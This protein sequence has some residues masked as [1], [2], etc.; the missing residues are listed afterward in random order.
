[1]PTY[2]VFCFR[3]PRVYPSLIQRKTPLPS[4]LP[5][6]FSARPVFGS[7]S[8]RRRVIDKTLP[9]EFPCVVI[10][11]PAPTG[12]GIL[13]LR[14]PWRNG[15]W[16]VERLPSAYFLQRLS[17][18]FCPENP[19]WQMSTLGLN[20]RARSFLI[21]SPPL[22]RHSV[23]KIGA[24]DLYFPNS[25]FVLLGSCPSAQKGKSRC[26]VRL[27]PLACPLAVSDPPEV[28]ADAALP[29]LQPS[30]FQSSVKPQ[31][32]LRESI[33]FSLAYV[34]FSR[35]FFSPSSSFCRPSL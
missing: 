16:F 13:D 5:T 18:V 19:C 35:S 17:Q 27:S 22:L 10:V 15:R 7:L 29:P 20:S 14:L 1:L 32:P 11:A 2:S 33:T 8:A 23:K 26:S 28:G 12:R 31:L 4:S 9:P 30:T 6:F 34:G 21:F 24:R 25:F 3:C